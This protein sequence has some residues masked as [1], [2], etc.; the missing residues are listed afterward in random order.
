MISEIVQN[1]RTCRT[2]MNLARVTP[3]LGHLSASFK[4]HIDKAV[5]IWAEIKRWSSLPRYITVCTLDAFRTAR[6]FKH[7]IT[8]QSVYENSLDPKILNET[9]VFT[10]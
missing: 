8:L 9:L 1:V 4:V 10:F 2:Q 3:P 6:Y 5:P 7:T